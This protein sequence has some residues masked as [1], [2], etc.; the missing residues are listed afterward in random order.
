MLKLKKIL[1]V[2]DVA[3][4]REPIAEALRGRGYD[5]VCAA[6]G[7]EALCLLRDQQPHLVLLDMAMPGL[8]GLAVLRTIRSNREWRS[9]PVIILTE[10]TDRECVESAT[11]HNIQGYL[12]K[13]DFS[14]S[15][16]L[17]RVEACLE[18]PAA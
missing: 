16:L 18:Q 7:W 1:V 6:S 10:K 8:D 17:A 5:V 9:L 14:L 3:I 4:C 13:S 11:S 12:L 15:D 2:E